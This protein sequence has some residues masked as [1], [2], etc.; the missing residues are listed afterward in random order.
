MT[1]A[2]ILSQ[3][4]SFFDLAYHQ[5]FRICS[6]PFYVR[7]IHAVSVSS[8]WETSTYA[9]QSSLIRVNCTN[10]EIHY[11]RLYWSIVLPGDRVESQFDYP[12][13]VI[14]L[15]NHSTYELPKLNVVDSIQ[16]LINNTE[17]I[18]GTTIKCVAI[19]STMTTTISVTTLVITG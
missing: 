8:P 9:P 19:D 10:K 13:S 5:N 11:S 14:L 16:L 18:N 15:N 17:G 3:L 4:G 2:I 7:V 6:L 1:E 12:S